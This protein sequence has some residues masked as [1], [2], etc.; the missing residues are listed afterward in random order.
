[1][2]ATSTGPVA[3]EMLERL[4]AALSPTRLELI[5]DS[6]Q[7]RGHGGYNPAGE[8]HFT[9]DDRKRRLRRQVAGR[10]A[11]AGLC[12]ARR[13]DGRAGP[14][15]VDPRHRSGRIMM[16][17]KPIIQTITPVTHDLG[18]FKVRRAL[19]TPRADDGRAV[20]LRRPVRP[21][22]AAARPGHGR[23]PAPAHQPRHRHLS[24]RRRDR[25]P[26]QHRHRAR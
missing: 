17:S 26:R 13:L 12:R 3:T 7:H 6:E 10:A 5:D 23:A 9:L 1:M 8:S 22:A 15:T 18:A 19:P 24:V 20:H 25:A 21:G 11:A 16:A 2:N 4:D 14:R